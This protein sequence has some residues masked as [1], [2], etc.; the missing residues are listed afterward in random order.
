MYMT[1]IPWNSNGYILSS[2]SLKKEISDKVTRET[3][4]KK[5]VQI[6]YNLYAKYKTHN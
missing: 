2:G 5:Q 4:T 1:V 6:W 3:N